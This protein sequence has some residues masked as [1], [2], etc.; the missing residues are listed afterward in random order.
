MSISPYLPQL[1]VAWTAYFIA[2]A[3]PGPAVMAIISTSVRSGRSGGMAMA[4]GVMTASVIWATTAALGL[5]ALL[6]A[7]GQALYVLKIMGGLYLF[8]L[9]FKALKSALTKTKVMSDE[10]LE[11]TGSL[12]GFY[13]KGLMVHLTNPKAIFVWIAMVSLGLPHDAPAY[14]TPVFI[15]G[16]FVVGVITMNAFA[17]LFSLRPVLAGYKKARR[18]IEGVMAAFFGFAAFKLVTAQI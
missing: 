10:G 17:L 16:C 4:M 5:A 13:L 11:P 14:V 12:S 2:V 7:Y 1:A 9:G 3:S 15:A 18:G 8:Y 6:A